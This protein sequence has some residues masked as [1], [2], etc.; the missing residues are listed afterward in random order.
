MAESESGKRE[1]MAAGGSAES[2]KGSMV[3]LVAAM[4]DYDR[5]RDLAWEGSFDRMEAYLKEITNTQVKGKK[6]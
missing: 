3:A 6:Q 1:G 5:Y 4:Q 2:P